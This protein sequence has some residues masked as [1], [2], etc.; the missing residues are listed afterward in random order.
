MNRH[1]YRAAGALLAVMMLAAPA[2]AEDLVD[3][4]DPEVILNIASGYGSASLSKDDYGDPLIE[5]RING[6]LYYVFFYDCKENKDCTSIQF[7]ATFDNPEIT[8]DGI[9]RWNKEKR[10]SSAYLDP[11][12]DAVLQYDLNLAFGV[13]RGNLDD[14]F[15]Y[16]RTVLGEFH[17]HL[18]W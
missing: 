12:G 5:G 9:N 6:L 13:S 17:D 7:S 3:G 10:F 11:D 14:T 16:W 15:D 4:K 8:V 1:A 2:A 18:G